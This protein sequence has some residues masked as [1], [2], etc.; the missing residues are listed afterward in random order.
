[1]HAQTM[2]YFVLN[3]KAVKK[4]ELQVILG[5][6]LFLYPKCSDGF[7]SRTVKYN[8]FSSLWVGCL[9]NDESTTTQE[10]SYFLSYQNEYVD[11]T[12]YNDRSK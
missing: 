12:F 8:S 1:M 4:D 7:C 9:K 3:R 5:R 2:N 10:F 6:M 11:V